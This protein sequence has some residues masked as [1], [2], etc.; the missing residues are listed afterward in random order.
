[1]KVISRLII[2]ICCGLI[3]WGAFRLWQPFRKDK[4]LESASALYDLLIPYDFDRYEI[5]EVDQSV[6]LF[7][8]V[9]EKED[10]SYQTRKEVARFKLTAEELKHFSR[11]KHIQSTHGGLLFATAVTPN[12]EWI[13]VFITESDF[14]PKFNK[15][16][17]EILG[18]GMYWF[19][20][21]PDHIVP[22]V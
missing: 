12:A 16:P 5:N 13:G 17:H 18:P 20:F 2:I 15:Y 22:Y 14:P 21:L 19:D 1:M 8:F 7:D 11:F 9:L 10:S 4:A 3:L 6:I